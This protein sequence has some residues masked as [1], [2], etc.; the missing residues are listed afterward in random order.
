MYLLRGRCV[1]VAT[2]DF[3]TVSSLVFWPETTSPSYTALGAVML[4]GGSGAIVMLSRR[5]AG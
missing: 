3:M 1:I 5:S 4:V 2:L